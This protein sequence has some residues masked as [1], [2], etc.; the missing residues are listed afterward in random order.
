MHLSSTA[1][2]GAPHDAGDPDLHAGIAVCHTGHGPDLRLLVARRLPGKR[3]AGL[4]EWPGG[5]V[6]PGETPLQATLRELAEET[7][8]QAAATDARLL[9]RHRDPGPPSIEFHVH[10]VDFATALPPRALQSAEA[11]WLPP[12]QALNREFPPT[13]EAINRRIRAWIAE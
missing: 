4:W 7:G 9:C 10:L 13:N 6:E 5:R 11:L 1:C 8:L 3:F 2:G 12:D